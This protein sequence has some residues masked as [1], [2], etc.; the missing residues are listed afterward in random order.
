MP[1]TRLYT[2]RVVVLGRDYND[3]RLAL[4]RTEVT[5]DDDV[6]IVSADSHSTA[7]LG[8]VAGMR[9]ARVYVTPDAHRGQ[10][11][12]TARRA[13]QACADRAQISLTHLDGDGGTYAS[14]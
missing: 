14:L 13:L 11:Y 3:A 7:I 12:E 2:D 6:T 9:V 4:K 10:N 1:L 8:G 5:A